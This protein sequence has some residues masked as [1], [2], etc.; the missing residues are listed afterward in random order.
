MSTSFLRA[1]LMAISLT[2]V[3]NAAI[4]KANEYTSGD[5]SGDLNF[6]HRSPFLE[7]VTM[8]DTTHSV[9]LAGAAAD[10]EWQAF[11]G[12]SKNDGVCIGKHLG[13]LGGECQNLDTVYGERTNCLR[14]CQMKYSGGP[15][16][17][18]CFEPA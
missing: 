2:A 17:S 16:L 12:K 18:T 13:P 3:V 10:L 4:P 15:V 1:V 8:D 9:Y 14:L 11:S 7:T 6:G 5:C